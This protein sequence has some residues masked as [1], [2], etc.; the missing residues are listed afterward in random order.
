MAREVSEPRSD[1]GK[2]TSGVLEAQKREHHPTPTLLLDIE[3]PP[4]PPAPGKPEIARHKP[5]PQTHPPLVGDEGS[6]LMPDGEGDLTA[7]LCWLSD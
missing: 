3:D 6:T 7:S 2:R 4:A 1:R 5:C